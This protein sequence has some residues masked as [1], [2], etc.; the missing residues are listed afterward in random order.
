MAM[1]PAAG[2]PAPRA[3]MERTER[4]ATQRRAELWGHTRQRP[5]MQAVAGIVVLS[6]PL[7]S[8]SV[9][10]QTVTVRLCPS[11]DSVLPIRLPLSQWAILHELCFLLVLGNKH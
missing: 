5:S 4:T 7:L 11:V 1:V 6:V 9:S 3:R 8:F 10:R 2:S